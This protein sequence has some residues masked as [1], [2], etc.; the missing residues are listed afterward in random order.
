M[1]QKTRSIIK[2][3]ISINISERFKVIDNIKMHYQISGSG[4]PGSGKSTSQ[5]D[6]LSKLFIEQKNVVKINPDMILT[7]LY[8]NDERCREKVNIINDNMFEIAY[9]E[10]YN[11]I[12]DGTGKDYNWT[13][14][15]VI[16]LLKKINYKVYLCINL[17][18]PDTGS[19]NPVPAAILPE[20]M[21]VKI[22]CYMF[23]VN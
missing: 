16:N 23:T 15:N 19:V 2:I 14:R 11:I 9:N 18:N 12:F 5:I 10:M 17:I 6:C 20:D 22:I 21:L 1:P 8:D 3:L 13:K 4:G 7:D